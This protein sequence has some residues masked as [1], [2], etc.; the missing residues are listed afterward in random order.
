MSARS[1]NYAEK[2]WPHD[3]CPY[4]LRLDSVSGYLLIALVLLKLSSALPK[5]TRDLFIDQQPR[6]CLVCPSNINGLD[7]HGLRYEYNG[8]QLNGTLV[9]KDSHEKRLGF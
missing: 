8:N 1:P 9:F 4:A 2:N 3:L 7:D 6:H 5:C